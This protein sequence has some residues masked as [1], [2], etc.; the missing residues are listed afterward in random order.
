MNEDDHRS[1]PRFAGLAALALVVALCAV[2]LGFQFER[3]KMGMPKGV[4][5]TVCFLIFAWPLASLGLYCFVMAVWPHKPSPSARIVIAILASVAG[6]V[7][8]VSAVYAVWIASS[9]AH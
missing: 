7:G 3:T 8:T 5:P 9:L 4:P 2:Y 1:T 6:L